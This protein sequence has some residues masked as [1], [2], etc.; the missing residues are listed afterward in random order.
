[1]AE[2]LAEQ[3][4]GPEPFHQLD[5][6][7]MVE[8]EPVPQE[9]IFEGFVTKTFDVFTVEQLLIAEANRQLPSFVHAANCDEDMMDLPAQGLDSVAV[10]AEVLRRIQE[11]QA[12]AA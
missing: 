12:E 9:A 1:M 10:A 8:I 7:S 3:P 2:H 4:G 6:S 5:I 11:Q